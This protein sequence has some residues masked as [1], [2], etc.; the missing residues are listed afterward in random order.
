MKMKPK[1]WLVRPKQSSHRRTTAMA[2]KEQKKP[3][4]MMNVLTYA[5]A[6]GVVIGQ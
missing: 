4:K 6:E 2:Q 3:K 5:G 1:K